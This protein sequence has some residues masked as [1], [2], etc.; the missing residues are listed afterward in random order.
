MSRGSHRSLVATPWRLS[1][2][3]HC[4]PLKAIPP[5]ATP[6]MPTTVAAKAVATRTAAEPHNPLL[7][8]KGDCAAGHAADAAD[9]GGG[10]GG[11]HEDKALAISG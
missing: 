3:I 1:L 4:W 10:Q 5:T 11:G 9:D 7:A 2:R 6:L 8:A